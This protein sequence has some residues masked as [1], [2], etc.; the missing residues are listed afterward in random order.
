MSDH[1]TPAPREP[2]AFGSN[3]WLVD[4]M[5]EQYLD[6]P[7]QL[8]ETWRAFF[9]S[10]GLSSQDT[11]A[12]PAMPTPSPVTVPSA[13]PP[14]PPA[15]PASPRETT[16]TL[17]DLP[18]GS[19]ATRLKGVPGRIADAMIDSLAVPTATSFRTF[20]SK[21]LEVNRR[22][23]NNQLA[24]LTRGGK[25]SF[26]HL[27]G[28]A[29][30][31]ALAARP[32]MSA[33][34]REVDGKAF[35]IRF[36]TINLGLA[37]DV[38]GKDGGRSLIVPNIKGADTMT[39]RD[40]WETYEDIVRRARSNKI[41]VDDFAGTTAT[42]TNPGTVGTGQSVPRLMPGQGVIIGVGRI[43]YA[44]EFEGSDPDNLAR[45]GVGRTLTMSSTYDHRV[46]QGADSGM[47]LRHIHELLLGAEDFYDEV[48]ESM[49]IPYVPARWAVDSSPPAGSG[50]WAE[51]QA[52]IF[53]LINMYRS[54]GHLIANLDPLS[55]SPPK[56]HPE[57]DPLTYGLTIWD[58]DRDFATG[59]LADSTHMKLGDILGVLR[60]AYCRTAGIEYMHIHEPTQKVWMQGHLEGHKQGP[61]RDEKLRILEKLNQAEAFERFLHTKFLGAKRFSLEGCEATIPL[62]DTILT[63]AAE[64]GMVD[65]SIGMAH[66]GR[67]NVL[68]NIVGK[69]LVR[70]FSEFTGNIDT[71]LDEG[72]SGDV[73][74]HL[75][76]HGVHTAP[77]GA[78]VRIE[79]AANPSHLEAVDP[80]LEGIVRAKQDALGEEGKYLALPVL[81]HGDAAFSGQGVVGETLNLSQLHGYATGGTVHIIINNQVGFTTAARDAR[82]SHYATDVAKAVEAPIFH[83]NGDDPE[84]VARV[85]KMA[86]AFRQAFKRDVVV[87]LIG[88]RRL[89][90]NEGDEPSFTQPK[91]YRI[92][93]NHDTVRSLYLERLV[94]SGDLSPDEAEVIQEKFRS[95]MDDA[96][97][98]TKA[99]SVKSEGRERGKGTTDVDTTVDREMLDF[100]ERRARAL[101]ES[102][103]VHPKLAKTLDDRAAL[104]AGGQLDWALG[105]ALAWGSL[106]ME[107]VRVRLAGEDSKRGT[108]S[109]RHASL[110][111]FDTE[112]EWIPLQHLDENQAQLRI[113]D[114]LLSEF[115]AMGFEYGYSV[116]DPDTLVM[117]EGQF[118]DFVNGA[119]VI[120]DQFITSG[121]YKW[122]QP[123]SLVLLLP[124]GFEGQGPEHSSARLE[125]FLQ[126]AAEDNIRIVV[127][128]TPAQHFHMMRR[129]ALASE[130]K[131]LVVMA[132]KSLLRTRDSYSSIKDV[133][134][135][136]FHKVIPDRD[137][138]SGARR[139]VLCQG[140][141]FYELARYRAAGNI[142]DV[143]LV[144]VEQLYPFP[145]ADI[146]AA[147]APHDGAELVWLQEE[148]A[149]MGAWRFMSRS[150]HVEAGL[151]ARGIYRKESSSPATGHSKVHATEQ[152]KL[153]DRAFAT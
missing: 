149:N 49:R 1:T 95:H 129:Q 3:D 28:W 22:I 46:I 101:P 85:A 86:F 35:H 51:K 59:G 91:M 21:L 117:W 4:Q 81:I 103:E 25:V 60:D 153:I 115:A 47:L 150:L 69:S 144:R 125:R 151:E 41:T 94:V 45:S 12:T 109:H 6:D 105:E 139:I 20:P 87:D 106:S 92:I 8:S 132:P 72:F 104:Y 9:D 122:N 131:P 121:E 141:G 98:E 83:V 15:E 48:F 40:F 53:Q 23:L 82:S 61:T 124:H 120:I 65:V 33:T 74:Y 107:G 57:L 137:V 10:G 75:G 16:G 13:I 90:H 73:K 32:A 34:Y 80:V 100:V 5:Y 38:P 143:A 78:T 76:A 52:K 64:A 88:Y 27:I 148:P 26:T 19:V 50:E 111:D 2:D 99:G 147:I 96:L 44:P 55:Q 36:N 118:G 145:A 116:Q 152:K 24:R 68:A 17:A 126:N 18:E 97:K 14:A 136:G 146:K 58:L 39:F 30:V 134:D 135:A 54:R 63:E 43:G 112:E 42:L 108:F 62:L 93:H 130:K 31:K 142:T 114:S 113:Y 71:P 79:V 110:V 84:A 89:G 66:R 56:I 7:S 127:P 11:A 123:S 140:K 133:T 67:L 138:P 70:I 29:T 119:Q 128:S 102:F 77:S 37:M